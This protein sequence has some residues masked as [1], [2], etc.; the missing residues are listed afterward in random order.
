MSKYKEYK[1]IFKETL[2]DNYPDFNQNL[3]KFLNNV[4][5]KNFTAKIEYI[6]HHTPYCVTIIYS[7]LEEIK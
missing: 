3:D 7:I 1:K 2:I 6:I 4:I 5:N